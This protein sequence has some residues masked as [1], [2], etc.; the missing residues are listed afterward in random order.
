MAL[1]KMGEGCFWLEKIFKRAAI[2]KMLFKG[3]RAE[4]IK[5]IFFHDQNKTPLEALLSLQGIKH[6]LKR[7]VSFYWQY[8]L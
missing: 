1:A 2:S 6:F 7:N 8:E 5:V 3:G 4:K